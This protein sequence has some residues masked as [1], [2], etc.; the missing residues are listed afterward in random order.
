MADKIK[1]IFWPDVYKEQ[2]RWLPTLAWAEY[3]HNTYG[4]KYVIE[5]LV[6]G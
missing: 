1:I 6:S 4:D 5:L 2:G 3:I